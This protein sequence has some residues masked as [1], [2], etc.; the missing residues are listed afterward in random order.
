MS[1]R[2][3][4]GKTAVV[5]GASRGI[6]RAIA[7]RLAAAGARVVITA[8]DPALLAEVAAEI[9]LAGSDALAL[10]GD[11]RLPKTAERIVEEAM[12]AFERIDILVNNAG[13]TKR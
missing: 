13:A 11:L 7:V 3:L 12:G 2:P 9:R 1:E 10:P 4:A 8:R 5:T 6:G